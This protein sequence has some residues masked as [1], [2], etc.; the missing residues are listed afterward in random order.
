[1]GK[2][3]HLFRQKALERISSPDRLDQLMHVVSSADWIP[4]IA[5][6]VLLGSG[7]AWS[8]L[9]SI[10]TMVNGRGVLVR[11]RRIVPIQALGGGRL[12]SFHVR[13]G[14]TVQEG[15]LLA[16][17]DQ[18]ELREKIRE[19]QQSVG[20]LR[21]QDEAKKAADD[22]QEKLQQEQDRLERKFLQAQRKNLEQGLADARAVHSILQK[23]LDSLAEAAR[24]GLVSPT[25]PDSVTAHSAFRD[26]D[27]KIADYTA[28]L[29][30]IDGQS[31]Q[32]ETRYGV[33]VQEHAEASVVRQNQISDL[34]NQIAMGT[35]QLT[36]SGDIPSAYAGTVTEVFASAGQVLTAG[37]RLISL[38]IGDAGAVPTSVSYFPVRDGKKIQP[39]MA[40]QITPDTVDRERF[41]GIVGKVI[42]VSRLPV[43]REGAVSTVGNP[44]IVASLMGDGAYIEVTAQLDADPSTSSGYRWSSS[45]GPDSKITSGI[46]TVSR[47]TVEKRAPITYLIPIL[48]ET[49]GV[50]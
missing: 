28:R 16:R 47:V 22:R 19:N 15:E 2:S 13:V 21:S 17:V 37:V 8:L 30:Q 14:D 5:L 11:P 43:T 32:I 24:L 41:G 39:G 26:N 42:S 29:E 1:M 38:D 34:Q 12:Q 46:T 48:R 50:Y 44:D 4:I 20:T 6:V 33:L 40:I 36:Q 18:P 45:R 31:K 10:P 25:G 7:V 9:G 49:S 27:A 3:D 35:L 23:R